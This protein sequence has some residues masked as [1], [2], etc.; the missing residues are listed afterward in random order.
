MVKNLFLV[1]AMTLC[2]AVGLSA[3]EA[4]KK[5]AL[6]GKVIVVVTHEVK[7]YSTWRKGYDADESNRKNAGFKVSGVYADANNPNMVTIIGEFPNAV[8]VDAFM[9]SP[10]LKE[11]MENAGVIGKPEVKM[12]TAMKK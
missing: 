9:T 2:L 8:A 3:Q 1:V 11:A 7:E 5:P 12:L 10:K 6:G 4:M